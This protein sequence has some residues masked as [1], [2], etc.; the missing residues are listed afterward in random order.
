[1]S[2][3]RPVAQ[4]RDA[5]VQPPSEYELLSRENRRDRVLTDFSTKYKRQANIFDAVAGKETPLSGM[6]RSDVKG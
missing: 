4:I 5:F 2:R 3:D 6:G 1:M